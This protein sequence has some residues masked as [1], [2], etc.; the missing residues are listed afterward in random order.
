MLFPKMQTKYRRNENGSYL[1]IR[2]QFTKINIPTY[3]YQ[4]ITEML[5]YLVPMFLHVL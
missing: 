3:T 2:V 5:S 4:S 1:E